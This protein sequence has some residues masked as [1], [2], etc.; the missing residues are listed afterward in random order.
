MGSNSPPSS[1]HGTNLRYSKQCR[2]RLSPGYIHRQPCTDTPG[3]TSSLL[4]ASWD[5]LPN[6]RS[7][8]DCFGHYCYVTNHPKRLET[9]MISYSPDSGPRWVVP[10][11]LA[12]SPSSGH[13]HLEGLLSWDFEADLTHVS[14]RWCGS[15][16]GDSTALLLA[17]LLT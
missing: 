2:R 9:A 4:R 8:P 15:W 6:T 14:R 1:L 7:S 10:L 5:H 13:I 3:L 17:S 12:R 16:R 11:R